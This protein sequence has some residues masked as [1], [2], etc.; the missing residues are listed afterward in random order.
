MPESTVPHDADRSLD[1]SLDL[2]PEGQPPGTE[3]PPDAEPAACPYCARPFRDPGNRALHV[4]ERHPDRQSPA[5]REAYETAH[6]AE[7]DELFMY[8]LRVIAAL[9]VVYAMLVLLYMIVL[10]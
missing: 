6:E 5:E 2:P 8:H 3:V 9:G 7:G 1:R 10:S 4:G